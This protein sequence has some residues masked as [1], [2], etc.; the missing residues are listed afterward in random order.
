MKYA[1]RNGRNGLENLLGPPVG[2]YLLDAR[3]FAGRLSGSQGPLRVG[4]PEERLFVHLSG[5]SVHKGRE[6][7]T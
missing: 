4:G 1:F 3:G 6:N 5:D 2:L 7:A